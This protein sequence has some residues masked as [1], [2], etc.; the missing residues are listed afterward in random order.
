[1]PGK[2]IP[3][4]PEDEVYVFEL[5][6]SR[7]FLENGLH[8]GVLEEVLDNNGSEIW[9]IMT[10]L[11]KEV[12]FPVHDRFILKMAPQDQRIVIDPPPGLLEIYGVKHSELDHQSDSH[13]GRPGAGGPEK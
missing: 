10:M 5:A 11:G 3:V 13:G 6:G 7:V 8:L 2:D 12:L 9:R 4:L 1:M